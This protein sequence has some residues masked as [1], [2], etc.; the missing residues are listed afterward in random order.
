MFGWTNHYGR[1][2]KDPQNQKGPGKAEAS[3][4][5]DGIEYKMLKVLPSNFKKKL[6]KIFNIILDKGEITS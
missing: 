3:P 2:R 4:G 5:K 6:L 1:I